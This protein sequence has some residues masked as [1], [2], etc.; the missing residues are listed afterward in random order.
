MSILS[1]GKRMFTS[2]RKS[3]SLF[4]RFCCP[5]SSRINLSSIVC[6]SG[7]CDHKLNDKKKIKIKKTMTVLILTPFDFIKYNQLLLICQSIFAF[8]LIRTIS[9]SKRINASPS[10]NLLHN[11]TSGPGIS[12]GKRHRFPPKLAPKWRLLIFEV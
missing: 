11:Q 8:S 10:S 6:F 3:S 12:Y 9:D 1:S 5:A 4:S 2:F 7:Y